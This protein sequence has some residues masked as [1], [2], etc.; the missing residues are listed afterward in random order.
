MITQNYLQEVYVSKDEE[1]RIKAYK[2]YSDFFM[3]SIPLKLS[4]NAFG[5]NSN[6][7]TFQVLMYNTDDFNREFNYNFYTEFNTPGFI[8][9]ANLTSFEKSDDILENISKSTLTNYYY[10]DNI[11]HSGFFESEFVLTE[12]NYKPH[13][14]SYEII[15]NATSSSLIKQKSYI[16]MRI[17]LLDENKSILDDSGFIYFQQGFWENVYNTKFVN[18]AIED[19]ISYQ[20]NSI[21]SDIILF[22]SANNDDIKIN[23][24]SFIFSNRVIDDEYLFSNIDVSITY[25]SEQSLIIQKSSDMSAIQRRRF[26][27]KRDAYKDNISSFYAYFKNLYLQYVSGSEE[28]VFDINISLTL[29]AT[30]TQVDNSILYF[31]KTITLN[32]ESSI[33]RTIINEIG[34]RIAYVFDITRNKFE[35]LTSVTPNFIKVDFSH[36]VTDSVI[37]NIL[38]VKNFFVFNNTNTYIYTQPDLNLNNQINLVN[39]NLS[40]L[41]IEDNTITFYVPNNINFFQILPR[42]EIIT[43]NQDLSSEPIFVLQSE[44]SIT[45][46]FNFSSELNEV[47][48]KVKNHFLVQSNANENIST[49]SYVSTYASIIIADIND[50]KT[51]AYNYGYYDDIN[52]E[53]SIISGV[54]EFFNNAVYQISFQESIS[55]KIVK[56][57]N[58]YYGNEI[59]DLDLQNGEDLIYFKQSFISTFLTNNL[60]LISEKLN[61]TKKSALNR[62]INS[63]RNVN[64]IRS[65]ISLVVDF[66]SFI[67][68][69]E[70][71]KLFKI[72]IIPLHKI[73]VDNKNNGTDFENNIIFDSTVSQDYKSKLNLNFVTLFYDTN[74]SFNWNKFQ[75]FKKAFFYNSSTSANSESKIFDL[76]KLTTVNKEKAGLFWPIWDYLFSSIYIDT[77]NNFTNNYKLDI[78]DFFDESTLENINYV[79]I[80]NFAVP[81]PFANFREKYF[82][83]QTNNLNKIKILDSNLSIRFSNFLNQDRLKPQTI[84]LINSNEVDSY[85]IDIDITNLKIFFTETEIVNNAIYSVKA[86]IHPLIKTELQSIENPNLKIVSLQDSFNS[87]LITQSDY[88]MKDVDNKSSFINY[89]SNTLNNNFTL[90]RQERADNDLIILRVNLNKLLQV[91]TGLFKSILRNCV[92]VDSIA[93]KDFYLRLGLNILINEKNLFLCMHKKINR[94]N[95]VASEINIDNVSTIEIVNS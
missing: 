60:H 86:A 20:L 62:F 36:N 73:L 28:F 71:L 69:M 94:V 32:R 8:S 19:V 16:A 53:N 1:R 55:N 76:Q 70:I 68:D 79:D 38:K 72:K 61:V 90:Y 75:Q 88:F 77:N 37:L 89:N 27:L 48:T 58:Y 35:I 43:Q 74:S 10:N 57:F 39:K 30:V 65:A 42:F 92:N 54:Y 3:F 15:L 67:K 14:S 21:E 2:G 7:K 56:K 17:F 26:S 87:N 84:S 18:M 11:I 63:I 13:I 85:F 31:T 80:K 5:E 22:P 78:K 29:N 46:N 64:D 50:F 44:E 49:S 45:N 93:L 23:I 91:N 81:Y 34:S 4:L 12:R 6:I 25:N 51:Y 24:P 33:I 59:F 41:F 9:S 52:N 83:F 47:N 40:D 95:L 82:N 66:E